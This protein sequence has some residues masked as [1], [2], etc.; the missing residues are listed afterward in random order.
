[1]KIRSGTEDDRLALFKLCLAMHAETDFM[2]YSLS[3]EKL[4]AGLSAWLHSATAAMFIA[5]HDTAGV[6]GFF[7]CKQVRP[8]FSDDLCV[9]EDCFYVAEQHRGSRAAYML[10]KRFIEWKN[11]VQALHWRAGVSSGAGPAGERLYAHFGMKN[12]GGN[13]VGHAK[14]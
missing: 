12:M 3:P 14:E 8:W 4:W 13:F 11:E 10:V 1:M 5:E 7:A 2:H 6:V 9:V